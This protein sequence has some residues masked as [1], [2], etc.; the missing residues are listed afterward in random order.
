[1]G[2]LQRKPSVP[3]P[4]P[5][6]DR[7][8]P[9]R[10]AEAEP[11]MDDLRIPCVLWFPG[12][13]PPD[14][15]GFAEPIRLPVR[16]VWRKAA[17]V[18]PPPQ[19]RL[20]E[21]PVT[22][23]PVGLCAG[24]LCDIPDGTH[25]PLQNTR[26]VG[27]AAI[28]SPV[29]TDLANRATNRVPHVVDSA[30]VLCSVPGSIEDGRWAV[31]PRGISDSGY[32]TAPVPLVDDKGQVVLNSNGTPMMRPAGMDP[33]FFVSEGLKDKKVEQMLAPYG[34]GLVALE[35]YGSELSKF[36]RGGSWDAQ[37]IGGSFHP[38]FVDY[39]TVAIGLYAAANGIPRDQILSIQ[40]IVARTSKYPYGTEMDQTYIHL[41]KRNIRNTDLGYLLYQ[42]GRI[43]VT[44][45]P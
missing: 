17:S 25:L 32:A 29:V 24:T 45:Q 6:S 21:P 19:D 5:A 2:P 8:G 14:L 31:N 1:M 43:G 39:A 34:G 38:E 18:E 30:V 12:D 13:P 27:Q 35:Y 23:M 40:D 16:V 36:W 28:N 33:H 3:H 11:V 44:A 20:P 15:S 42:S 10:S 9:A 37:R 7:S 26:A 22:D 4:T 41:P